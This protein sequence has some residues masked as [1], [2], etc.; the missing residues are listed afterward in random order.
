MDDVRKWLSELRLDHLAS[1][2]AKNQIDFESLRL[3]SEEDLQEMQIPLGPRRK[4]LAGIK[5]LN[6][7]HGHALSSQTIERRQLTILFCDLV[8]STEYANQLDPEDFTKLTQTYLAACTRAVK[9]HNGI[10]AN[11]IGDAFQALFGYPIAEEDDG[12]RALRL[13]FDILRIVPQIEVPRGPPLRVRIGIASGLVVVGDFVGAPAGVSTVALGSIPNLAQRLQT[14]AEPQ[15][16]L[17]DLKTYESAAGAFEFAD[18]GLQTLKGFFSPLHIWRAEKAKNLENRFAKRTRLTELV[19]RQEEMRRVLRLWREV[20]SE[21]RGQALLITGEPGI[22]KS[23]LVFEV[24]RQIP[25][26]TVLTIQC[27]SAY[28]NSALF[29]FLSLLKRYAGINADD[30]PDVSLDK[31]EAVLALSEVPISQS[32][33]IFADLLSMDQTRYPA[34]DLTAVRQRDISHKFLTDWL[35]HVSRISPVL[36]LIEDEHWIDPSSR[37]VVGMLIGEAV[38]FPMLILITSRE[39]SLSNGTEPETLSKIGL[40]RLNRDE[41]EMLV[42]YIDQ[43]K[44][45]SNETSL[46][47]LAKAEG[48]PLFVEELTRAVLAMDPSADSELPDPRT[49]TLAVPSSLQSSLLSRLDKIG[50]A[51]AVAQIAAVVGREFDAKLV[52]HLCGVTPLALDPTLRRLVESDIVIRQ[53]AAGGQNYAFAHSLLQESARDTLLRERCR[54]L[55]GQVA[56]AIELVHPKLAA[57]HPEVL[58]QH[59]AE[60]GLFERAADCWL[61]AGLNVGKTWAKVEA[62]NMLANGLECLA[63]LPPSAERD[64]KELRL[65]LERGDVLYATFGYVTAGGGAAYRNV[66][67]LSEKLG[68]TQAPIRA[69]DGIFGTA[70]N[71]ARFADALW[72][73]DQLIDIGRNRDS[74][75][76]AVLGMQFKGMSLFAQGQ[77]TQAREYLEAALLHV[78]HADEIG[79]DFPSMAMSY[80]AWTLQLIGLDQ[81]AIELYRDAEADARRHSA[82]RLAAYL[83]NGCILHAFREDINPLRRMVE[84]LAVLAEENGF[85]MWQNMASFFQG[86]LMVRLDNNLSGLAKM[87]HTCDNLGEQQTDKSCYLGLLADCYLQS[88]DL[89]ACFATLNQ[90]LELVANTGEN[91]F[92]AELLRLKGEALS[93]ANSAQ[94][95]AESCLSKAIEFARRQEAH[96]W[97]MKAAKT[98]H[99]IQGSKTQK[100]GA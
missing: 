5:L 36:L 41:A 40:E 54:E 17:T 24:Q 51:K 42:R 16:I 60:A 85:R 20:I 89:D 99:R 82:Y 1:I 74:L 92:T 61:A 39:R 91:Y 58:A 15:T 28:S 47:L 71:S 29:P 13:A 12:E 73:S 98:L 30:S 6:S 64:R 27:S 44:N 83:G 33:P 49:S 26:C 67:R 31:L 88:G 79:S 21:N 90:A 4:I 19:D 78:E 11:Y 87:R 84:E 43:D 75:K 18:L 2:F 48:V 70:F 53:P 45:L 96:A 72:A 10:T 68:D 55:H 62:A 81:A 46:S 77:F 65:E 52:A 100:P 35:H 94:D 66:L 59:F 56:E 9:S 37:E 50:P 3:L 7:E 63:K 32:L 95:E 69:L 34:T 76:A 86:W 97:E 14:L 25:Q 8:G 93:R 80:L 22:G 57:E 23:R 38:S